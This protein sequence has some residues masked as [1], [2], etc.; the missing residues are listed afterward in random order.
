MLTSQALKALE[1]IKNA[2]G[3]ATGESFMEDHEPI[4]P[5]L[6]QELRNPQRLIQHD[7]APGRDKYLI[8]TDAGHAVLA[9]AICAQSKD[10]A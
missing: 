6:W 9:T 4:G 1:Y 7:P 3:N 5:Q 2:G 8:L 10:E